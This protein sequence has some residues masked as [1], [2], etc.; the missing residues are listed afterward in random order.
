MYVDIPGKIRFIFKSSS[1]EKN[2]TSN[3]QNREAWPENT[4]IGKE[5]PLIHC[6]NLANS[7][8]PSASTCHSVKW[9]YRVLPSLQ[10]AEKGSPFYNTALEWPY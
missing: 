10:R 7:L 1:V 6:M 3:D 9:G 2:G 5:L 8:N 4:I